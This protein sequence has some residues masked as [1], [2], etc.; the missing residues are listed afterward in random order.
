MRSD[1]SASAGVQKNKA[2]PGCRSSFLRLCIPGPSGA[3]RETGRD[4]VA[5]RVAGRETGGGVFLDWGCWTDSSK[6]DYK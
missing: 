1:R 2:G 4:K 6:G 3:V 5:F